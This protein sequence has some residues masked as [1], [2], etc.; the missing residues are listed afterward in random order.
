MGLNHVQ[1]KLVISHPAQEA[2]LDQGRLRTGN[3]N[4][5][6]SSV[7]RPLSPQAARFLELGEIAKNASC[8]TR[9]DAGGDRR[10]SSVGVAATG[11]DGSIGAHPIVL[12]PVDYGALATTG[13]RGRAF[14]VATGLTARPAA[15]VGDLDV[16]NADETSLSPEILVHSRTE[17][18]AARRSRAFFQS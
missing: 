12:L 1:G 18:A 4:P 9:K 6:V 5:F 7:A 15:S 8:R 10:E 17:G 16:S 13:A 11:S 3:P 2:L 14:F